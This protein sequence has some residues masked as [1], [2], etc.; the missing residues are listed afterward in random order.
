MLPIF[1]LNDMVLRNVFICGIIN[2]SRRVL[3]HM[4]R[5]SRID[6]TDKKA[7]GKEL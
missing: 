1:G 3:P 4:K 5:N 7:G 2:F 6:K